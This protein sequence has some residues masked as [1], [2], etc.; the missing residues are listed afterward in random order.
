MLHNPLLQCNLPK[1][2]PD[3]VYG[4]QETKNFKD[5]FSRPTVRSSNLRGKTIGESVR[6]SPFKDV[7]DPLLFPF[8]ILEAKSDKSSNGFDDIS[9][10]TAFPT[11]ALLRL[12]EELARQVND[13]KLDGGPLVW[14]FANR[15]DAWRV[16][17]CYVTEETP[18]GYL[19]Q[20]FLKIRRTNYP[21][22]SL[23]LDLTNIGWSPSRISC[24][25]GKGVFFPT[26][27]P[28]NSY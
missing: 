10:Q 2:E 3:R 23:Y 25:Y 19:R 6:S 5:L 18:I 14:F 7:S 22:T 26:T 1:Q 11:Y 27:K 9:I 21:Q 15:G 4:L 20:P 12:Q 8:L 24:N 17:G 13:D 28:F 16:Y